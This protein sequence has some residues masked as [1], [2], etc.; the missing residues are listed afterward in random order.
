MR[1]R[2]GKVIFAQ[3]RAAHG[4][5]RS[6]AWREVEAAA[7]GGADEFAGDGVVEFGLFAGAGTHW[8]AM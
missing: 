5:G 3:G 2:S 1:P 7:A 6:G 4:H 8:P